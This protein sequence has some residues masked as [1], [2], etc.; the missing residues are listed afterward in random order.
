[1]P[2]DGSASV[3]PQIEQEIAVEALSKMVHSLPQSRQ[4]TLRK[5][6]TI[7]PPK[8]LVHELE[9]SGS[10]TLGGMGLS[11]FSA[12]V[13]EVD[14]LSRLLA[15][16]LGTGKSSVSCR[17][18]SEPSL[19]PLEFTRAPLLYPLDSVL[20]MLASKGTVSHDFPWHLHHLLTQALCARRATDGPYLN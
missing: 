3:E 5:L 2:P 16:W 9:L 7:I 13:D 18:S 1:L 14:S 10:L 15:R 20:G 17:H 6:P 12:P 8:S 11:S 4:L 19:P